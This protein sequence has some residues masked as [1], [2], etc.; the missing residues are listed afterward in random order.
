MRNNGNRELRMENNESILPRCC[1]W[2][3]RRVISL[4][5]AHCQLPV[6]ALI[7]FLTL[8]TTG[9]LSIK[10][11]HGITA[12]RQGVF[13]YYWCNRR[14]SRLTCGSCWR[15]K[16]NMSRGFI[17]M[18]VQMNSQTATLTLIKYG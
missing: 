9:L 10:R 1:C 12:V 13:W 6:L 11:R 15:R 14:F 2:L 17:R 4:Q 16:T 8:C 18:F 3:A 5:G 7:S